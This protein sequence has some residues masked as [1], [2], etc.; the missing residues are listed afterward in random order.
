MRKTIALLVA[1]LFAFSCKDGTEDLQRIDQVGHIYIDSL[2]QDMLNSAIPG[3]YYSVTMNDVYGDT[4]FSPV[5]YSTG[6]DAD[7]ISYITYVSGA[8]RLPISGSST[9]ESKIALAL[10]KKI[11]DSVSKT[12]N[13][14]MIIR[15][16]NTPEVFQINSVIY[17]GATVFTKTP[18]LPNTIKVVK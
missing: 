15:Y 5:S 16:D 11:N 17:N 13:D 1:G 4:D 8:K 9:Y 18:G 2:G 3:S 7:T 6:K 10:T 12:S 14:T